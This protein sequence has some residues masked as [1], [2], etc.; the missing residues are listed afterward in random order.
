METVVTILVLSVVWASQFATASFHCV[1]DNGKPV[2]WFALYK[3]P[4]IKGHSNSLIRNGTAFLFLNPQLPQWNN[5]KKSLSSKDNCLA[6]TLAQYYSNRKNNKIFYF[7]YNDQ[8]KSNLEYVGHTKGV[9]MFDEEGGFWLIHSV[10]HFPNPRKY[11][12]PSS[13]T[14]YGQSALCITFGID[15][16]GDISKQLYFNQ[17]GIYG[18]N[19]PTYFAQKFPFL[20]MTLRGKFP[21]AKPY[22]STLKLKSLAG[23][24][25]VSFAK[26]KR[27][28]KELYADKVAKI[29]KNCLLVETWRNGPGNLP[30][31]CSG[32]F[33]VFNVLSVKLPP[34]V[35]FPTTRDHSKW[36]VSIKGDGG[37]WVCIGDINRQQGQLTRAG[38]TVCVNDATVW[39]VYRDS[40]DGVE[41]CKINRRG[42][43]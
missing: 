29:L 7:L 3:L 11:E 2:D 28:Q 15:V 34:N 23:K 30:S 13:A 5:T 21:R 26:S 33:N 24:E 10:P 25:F 8:Q 19:L 12:W 4:H 31:S 16:L 42:R 32:M 17:P 18:S 36:V 20:S 22:Y 35:S 38:G 40:V 27:W 39:K 37:G 1:G 41:K 43:V 14:I 9:V 6:M